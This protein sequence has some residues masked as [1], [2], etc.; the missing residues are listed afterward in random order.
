MSKEIKLS[1]KYG[2]NPSL[3]LCPIC[4]KETSIAIMG[5]IGKYKDD[6]E[7]P[8]Q[9]VGNELCDDC[10]KIIDDG[11]MFILEIKDNT[12]NE[13][14]GR[15]IALQKEFK[16]KNDIKD[17]IVCMYHSEFEQIFGNQFE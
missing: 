6:R 17:N 15:Y 8:R 12:Q 10:K 4:M 11:G 5:K 3:V 9:V 7:A 13:R 14:T 16:E 1:P 2:L